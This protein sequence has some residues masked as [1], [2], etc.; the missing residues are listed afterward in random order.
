MLLH[1]EE[2]REKIN[3]GDLNMPNTQ[4]GVLAAIWKY[5]GV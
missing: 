2:E 1:A 3:M 4:E 5:R